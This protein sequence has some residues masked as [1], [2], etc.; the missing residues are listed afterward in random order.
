MS[1]I[2]AGTT[3][4]TALVSTGDTTGA[5]VLQINGTTTS[6]TL[7]AN[8]SVGVGSSPSYGTNGQVL[9][10]AGSAAAPTWATPASP[11]AGA[12]TFLSTVTASNSSTVDIE[13]TFSSTYNAYLLVVSNIV[14]TDNNANL[15]GRFKLSGAYVTTSTYYGNL[16]N[17]VSTTATFNADNTN[18]ATFFYVGTGFGADA[19]DIAGFNINIY[20]PSSTTKQ[21]RVVFTGVAS[22]SSGVGAG[23]TTTFFGSGSNSGTGAMTGL[24]FFMSAGTITSGTFRLY[25]IANS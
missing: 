25:G 4:G 8:G 20:N 21:K 2:S 7:A 18:A 9:T 5:L 22:G 11:P 24:R 3:S 14:V 17:L 16:M 23:Q 1:T 6:V 15:L 10:S 12:L 19:S 13:T